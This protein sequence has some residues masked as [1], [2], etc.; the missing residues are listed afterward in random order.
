MKQILRSLFLVGMLLL[1]TAQAQEPSKKEVRKA[2]RAEKKAQTQRYMMFGLGGGW[3]NFQDLQ[4]SNGRYSGPAAQAE[5]RRW[6]ISPKAK[7]DI[8]WFRAAGG[9]TTAFH[10]ATDAQVFQPEFRFTYTHNMAKWGA[11]NDRI[12][13]FGGY[14]SMMANFRN[15]AALNNSSI[16]LDVMPSIGPAVDIEIPFVLPLFKTNSTFSYQAATSLFAFMNALP[17][18]SLSGGESAN[19]F[20]PFG[21]QGRFMSEAAMIIPIRKKNANMLKISYNWELLGYRESEFFK[22]R[23]GQHNLLFTL[24]VNLHSSNKSS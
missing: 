2:R 1:G 16:Y 22:A 23:F 14:V 13:R 7:Q 19:Y 4:M 11:K 20:L 5:W 18:Y 10:G 8:I 24:M 12:I 3:Y 9:L 15:N 21:R 17:A 6:E